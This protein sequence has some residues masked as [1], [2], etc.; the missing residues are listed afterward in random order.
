MKNNLQHENHM[1]HMNML[2]ISILKGLVKF[3]ISHA[4]MLLYYS[5]QI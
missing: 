5:Y 4:I 3:R 2:L 1:A